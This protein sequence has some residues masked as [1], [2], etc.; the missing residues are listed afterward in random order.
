MT[1]KRIGLVAGYGAFPLE[2][3][4]TL[5]DND[6][7]VHVAAIQEEASKAIESIADSVTWV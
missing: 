6:F 2:L 3:A 7:Y 5:K 1:D 4:Q